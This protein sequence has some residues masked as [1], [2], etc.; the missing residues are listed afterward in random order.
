[1]VAKLRQVGPLSWWAD[2][3]SFVAGGTDLKGRGGVFRIDA[4]SGV[5]TP[6]LLTPEGEI[7]YIS[8][9]A[10]DAATV[11]YR[12]VTPAAVRI[13]ARDVA[14]G[15]ERAL[16]SQPRAPTDS[17]SVLEGQSLSPDGS[18]IATSTRESAR[19]PATLRAISTSTGESR[20][21]SNATSASLTV[22]M[23]APD[24]QSLFVRRRQADGAPEVLRLAIAGGE[25]RIVDW[26]LGHDTHD[27]RVH[28]DGRRLVYVE[29][30]SGAAAGRA[31]LRVLA[32]I[33]R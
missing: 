25:P 33:A 30:L 9:I 27:F 1:V 12:Q 15:L 32:G 20:A 22:L 23:W 8:A 19:G 5:A 18:W 24:S 26:T 11:Y 21:L 31:E 29:R 10:P 2:S 17:P 28:P 6:L 16:L 4:H 3:G 7:P 14:S 13:V